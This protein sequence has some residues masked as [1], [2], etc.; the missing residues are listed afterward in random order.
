M[1]SC[2]GGFLGCGVWA[3]LE[4]LR[5]LVWVLI[6]YCFNCVFCGCMLDWGFCWFSGIWFVVCL[7][8]VLTWILVF[9]VGM[10]WWWFGLVAGC[11]C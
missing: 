4:L 6:V 10:F 5:R 1:V 7:G 8:L 3:G 11:R 2:R 9:G